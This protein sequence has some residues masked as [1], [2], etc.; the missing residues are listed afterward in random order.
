MT[1]FTSIALA[2]ALA[3]GPSIASAQTPPP[4]PPAE[5]KTQAAAYV[6]AAGMSDLYEINS[7]QVALQ[8]SQN[9]G[10][11]KYAQMMIDHHQKTTA[12]TMAAARK[13]GMEPSPPMLDAG[14]TASINEL[15]Q[16]A[17]ADFDR[18]YLGQQIPAHQA[19]LDLHQSYARNGDQAALKASA[20]KA[21]PIVKRHLADAQ[22]MQG[23]MGGATGQ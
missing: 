13:A 18:L 14:A 5:A 6:K 20:K 15:Q 21:V 12:A 2:F 23:A 19:A 1:K 9:A 10:I 11:K 4:P 16:A 17:P 3:A 7:S 22:K 8:K